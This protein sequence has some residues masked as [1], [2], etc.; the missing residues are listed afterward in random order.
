[1][2]IHRF[3][4]EM[5]HFEGRAKDEKADSATDES[6]NEENSLLELIWMKLV[7]KG[8]LFCKLKIPSFGVREEGMRLVFN[9]IAFE[10]HPNFNKDPVVTSYISFL[11]S[12]IAT[13]EDVA[14]LRKARILSNFLPNDEDVL[15]T[16][17]ELTSSLKPYPDI[18]F[19]TRKQVIKYFNSKKSMTAEKWISDAMHVYFRSPWTTIAS[20]SATILLIMTI[21]QAV[22]S[23]LAYVQRK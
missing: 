7:K 5:I 11:N 13:K 22:F 19:G 12:L 21:I 8:L 3:A 1:M 2:L 9:L 17:R 4:D 18:F 23:V 14:E 16:F 6:F 20:I 15:K 10:M